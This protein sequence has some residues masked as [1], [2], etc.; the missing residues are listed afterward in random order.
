MPYDGW[1]QATLAQVRAALEVD[2][3]VVAAVLF[4]SLVAHSEHVD[5]WS[6]VDLLIVVRDGTRERFFP[7]TAW[8]ERVGELATWEHS[9][10][11]HWG[12]IRAVLQDLRRI[13]AGFVEEGAMRAMIT[14]DRHPLRGSYR[15]LFS[16]SPSVNAALASVERGAEP[17]RPL[18]PDAFDAMCRE[19]WFVAHLALK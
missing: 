3:D 1:Q 13:D 6:D 18:A 17:I 12:V 2:D 14:G 19:F 16:R 5:W 7:T 8:L 10:Y 15:T 4:D 11:E 9:E